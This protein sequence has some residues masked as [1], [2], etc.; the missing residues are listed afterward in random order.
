MPRRPVVVVLLMT[1]LCIAGNLRPVVSDSTE[2]DHQD[3]SLSSSPHSIQKS[4]RLEA[5]RRYILS[6]LN[7]SD[8]RRFNRSDSVPT[9][10][11]HQ[12]VQHHHKHD[13]S[14][15][16]RQ[17]APAQSFGSLP[18]ALD[19]YAKQLA[20]DDGGSGGRARARVDEGVQRRR[21]RLHVRD[22]EATGGTEP[23]RR[24]ASRRRSLR[25]R[26]P[27]RQI[28]LTMTADTGQKRKM[29]T[30]FSLPWQ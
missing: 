26:H 13:Q 16:L 2:P 20:E 10:T 19:F 14:D 28:K 27:R 9:T 8:N 30:K 17:L 3:I 23:K 22:D 25:K 29:L 21:R 1:A 7:V 4:D 24:G 11:H 6:R 5:I 15:Q 12:S 18:E